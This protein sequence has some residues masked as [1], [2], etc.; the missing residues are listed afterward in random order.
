MEN[1]DEEDEDS[2]SSLNKRMKSNIS[3][4]LAAIKGKARTGKNRTSK[5]RNAKRDTRSPYEQA[6]SHEYPECPRCHASMIAVDMKFNDFDKNGNLYEFYDCPACGHNFTITYEG[7][8]DSFH[9][10]YDE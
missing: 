3:G 6:S 2:V 1:D 4:K 9:W 7:P 8:N 10:W 5:N